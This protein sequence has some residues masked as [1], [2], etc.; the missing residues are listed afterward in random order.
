MTKKRYLMY[1]SQLYALAILRPLQS[2]IIERGDEVAW[3][4]DG[5]GADHL[6]AHE[7]H[8]QSVEEVKTFEPQAVFVPGNVVPDFF[9]GIK[10]QVFHGLATDDTGKKGHYRIRGFF[11][12]YCTR[13]DEETRRFQQ[14]AQ[15]YRYFRVAQTGWPKLDPLFSETQ[16]ADLHT[17]L[18]IDAKQPVVL[19][20][21][22]FS[23]SLTS[24]PFL[25]E[26][27]RQL[28][29]QGDFFWLV[30]LH[31]KT[32]PDLVARYRGLAGKNLR[33][34]E[35][36]EDIVPLL[37]AADVM[38]CD[39]SSI[40]IEF[41]MLDKPL[42]TFRAKCPG[43]QQIDVRD[44]EKVETALNKALQRPEELMKA[45]R[46]FTHALHPWNDG[47]SSQRVL[48]AVD[49]FLTQGR[50]GLKPKPFNLLRKWKMRRKLVYY[51]L[52]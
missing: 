12:L 6:Q 3:F 19:Y 52:I 51:H 2:A 48:E 43:P 39:T 9:P 1:G 5:P 37:R 4:F 29:Q 11:D 35:S 32:D 24:A 17:Q 30:T 47:R 27:I 38:L 7:R 36:H 21:S 31:P 34:F 46:Q 14:L 45:T 40:A 23:P 41:Q 28:A 44:S 13:G 20:G 42:V 26:T 49:Q 33:F 16:D 8:L 25:Y 15:K 10:V 22:T 50:A 18:G